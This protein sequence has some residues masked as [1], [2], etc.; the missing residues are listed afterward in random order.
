M[1]IWVTLTPDQL[2]YAD[3]VGLRRHNDCIANGAVN[4][5][6]RPRNIAVDL[7][8]DQDAARCELAAHIGLE[9]KHWLEFAKVGFGPKRPDLDNFID[10]K[11]RK[12]SRHNLII[13]YDDPA[14]WAYLSV[15]SE[16]SPDFCIDAWC[17]GY[18]VQHQRFWGEL[19]PGRPAYVISPIATVIKNPRQLM[20]L[21]KQKRGGL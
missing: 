7:K 2:A 13:Q 16:Q 19:V 9:T 3:N 4:R 5:N 1:A 21:A 6:N 20:Q 11:E 8:N 12:Q 18:E 15:C 10:V 17:W 14:D